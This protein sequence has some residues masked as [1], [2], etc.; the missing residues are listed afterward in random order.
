MNSASL[1]F[2]PV[3]KLKEEGYGEYLPMFEKAGQEVSSRP[4]LIS[5]RFIRPGVTSLH[6]RPFSFPSRLA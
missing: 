6:P 1:R 4:G 5:R 3:E 2:V